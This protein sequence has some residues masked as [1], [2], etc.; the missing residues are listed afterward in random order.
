MAETAT[1]PD[2]AEGRPAP[3]TCSV[4]TAAARLGIGRSLAYEMAREG[5]FPVPVLR[6]GRKL[7]IPT[8]ALDR[9]LGV[10]DRPTLAER[11]A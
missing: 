9:V 6:L 1:L 8:R 10:E 7:V 11:G 5:R 2:S 3:E 4:E